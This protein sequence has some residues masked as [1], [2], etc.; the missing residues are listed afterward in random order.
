MQ[1]V[2]VEKLY[3]QRGLIP[4]RTA[5]TPQRPV[6]AT[7]KEQEPVTTPTVPPNV[8]TPPAAT[9]EASSV[10]PNGSKSSVAQQK[11]PVQPVVV[12]TTTVSQQQESTAAKESQLTVHPTSY[13]DTFLDWVC[14]SVD[15][16]PERIQGICTFYQVQELAKLSSGQRQELTK[17]LRRQAS[18][19]RQSASAGA[20]SV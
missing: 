8:T 16:D 19:Q 13:I 12:A 9:A 18:E 6:P 14:R 20:A 7:T 17:R 5:S 15:R 1:I 10:Q 2:W 4:P 3:L 11:A